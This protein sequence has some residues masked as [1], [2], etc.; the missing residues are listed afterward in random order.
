MAGGRVTKWQGTGIQS[1]CLHHCLRVPCVVPVLSTAGTIPNAL[2]A[3]IELESLEMY[4]NQLEG[5]VSSTLGLLTELQT[6]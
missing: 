5:T 1:L 2:S 3:L 6:L 4:D